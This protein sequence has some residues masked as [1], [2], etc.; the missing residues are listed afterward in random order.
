MSRPGLIRVAGPAVRR[1]GLTS[2]LIATAGGA[3]VSPQS[4]GE[5]IVC[6]AGSLQAAFNPVI[7]EFTRQHPTVVVK[8][9]SGGSVALAGRMAA[10]TQRCDV[11]AAADDLDIDLLLKPLKLADYTVVFARGRMVLAYLDTDPAAR[12][13]AAAGEFKPPDSIPGAAADWYRILLQPGVR[14]S[15]SHPFLDPSGYRSHMI[16]QLAETFYN[17][18]NLANSLL[19]HYTILPAVGGAAAPERTLGRDFNF[20]LI[21]EHSAAAAAKRNAAY[22]YVALPDRIDL[23]TD[24]NN[25]GYAKAGVT[26]PG[27]APPGARSPV[28][29]PAARVAWGLT[30]PTQSVNQENAVAFVSLLLGPTG[31]AALTTHGPAPITPALVSS[32]DHRRLPGSLQPLVKAA[33]VMP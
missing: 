28:S 30:I 19:E 24:G 10:G 21:Y 6:H 17:V 29:I 13:I 33:R 16:F 8:D 32:A 20:Q 7:K 27:I 5:L 25:R 4:A 3:A 1:L 12:G 26:M 31:T 11:Y 14:I 18:P 15:G 23:S 22:R 2:V 9:V